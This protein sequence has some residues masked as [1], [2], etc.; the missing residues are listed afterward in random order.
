MKIK[1]LDSTKRK[2]AFENVWTICK[3]TKRMDI[4]CRA[5]IL[6]DKFPN[7][8]NIENTIGCVYVSYILSGSLLTDDSFNHL[9]YNCLN[10]NFEIETMNKTIL[11]TIRDFNWDCYFEVCD[12]L[13]IDFIINNIHKTTNNCYKNSVNYYK[14]KYISDLFTSYDYYK[15]L[16]N[17]MKSI[18]NE[19]T[20]DSIT[21]LL[22]KEIVAKKLIKLESTS[23]C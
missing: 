14:I 10:L 6:I 15:I 2:L 23:N 7:E 4:L 8:I 17:T 18:D 11:H 16:Y 5:L 13:L 19:Y 20:L 9:V 21:E 22:F 1:P 3:K 12:T